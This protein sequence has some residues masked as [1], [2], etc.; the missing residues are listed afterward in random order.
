VCWLARGSFWLNPPL[1]IDAWGNWY[2]RP[3]AAVIDV[4]LEF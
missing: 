3:A 2:K 4:D 1:A